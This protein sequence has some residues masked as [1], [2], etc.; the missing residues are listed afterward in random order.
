MNDHVKK[1]Y[2]AIT[3]NKVIAAGT[4]VMDFY[5]AFCKATGYSKGYHTFRKL[6]QDGAYYT[7]QIGDVVYYFQ[8]LV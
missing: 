8:N 4:N 5:T 3:G 1:L 7:V 6:L 2:V